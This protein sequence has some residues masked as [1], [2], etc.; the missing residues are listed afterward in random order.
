M[1]DVTGASP[2]TAGAPA[3]G[4]TDRGDGADGPILFAY[5]GSELAGRAIEI[6]G[7]QLAPG[8]AAVV[9]CVWQPADVCFSPVTDRHFDAGNAAEVHRAAEDTAAHGA[10]L[11]ERVGF[12]AEAATVEASPSWKGIVEA[13]EDHRAGVIVIGSHR[14]SGLLGHLSGSVASAVVAH[15]T[16]PVLLVHQPTDDG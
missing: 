7:R 16:L 1:A 15:S 6:G 8:R 3:G 12:R 9:V 11:A 10:S 5:D 4:R 13:A 2:A 14:H